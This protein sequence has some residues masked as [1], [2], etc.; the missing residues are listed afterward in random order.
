MRLLEESPSSALVS[1]V[2]DTVFRIPLLSR[3]KEGE[4]GLSLV[5]LDLV[6]RGFGG[7]S[8]GRFLSTRLDPVVSGTFE[9]SSSRGRFLLVDT[10]LSICVGW[11]VC[12]L[13][14]FNLRPSFFHA[15]TRRESTASE[16][17]VPLLSV[18]AF[19][20]VAAV[21]LH[22]VASSAT[23]LVC[24]HSLTLDVAQKFG[25]Q[26]PPKF[27]GRPKHKKL[28]GR[29]LELRVP[30]TSTTRKPPLPDLPIHYCYTSAVLLHILSKL[31]Q[32]TNP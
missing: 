16:A 20:I 27:S 29:Q 28:S 4:R 12:S 13:A 6:G 19:G 24:I 3:F 5:S 8:R 17:G 31:Q 11:S 26:V 30:Q 25:W 18:R 22:R 32:S 10:L 2:N 21:A 1:D 14:N 23:G 9:E 15:G 7:S